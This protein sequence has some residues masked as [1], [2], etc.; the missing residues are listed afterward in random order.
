MVAPPTIDVTKT[1]WR[2][3]FSA[4]GARATRGRARTS[5]NSVEALEPSMMTRRDGND[6]ED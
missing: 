2:M 4:H 5:A 1:V 6:D 3:E